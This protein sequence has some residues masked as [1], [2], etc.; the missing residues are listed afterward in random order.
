VL[1]VDLDG[2]SAVN[3][4]LGHAAGDQLLVQSA[5]RLRASVRESDI[6]ARLSGDEF[7][8]ALTE[9]RTGADAAVAARNVITALS[10]SSALGSGSAFISASVGIALFPADGES[11][12]TLLQH[13]DMAMYRAKQQ[14]RGQF[15]FFEASM[16]A[17]VQRRIELEGELRLALERGEFELHYQPQLDLRCARLIGGEALIRWRHPSKGMVPPLQFIGHAETN[18]LIEPIGRWALEMACAQFVSWR[19]Q[20]VPIE[21]VSVNVSPRQFRNPDFVRTVSE[22]LTRAGM[23]NAFMFGPLLGAIAL[24]SNE[25]QFSSVPTWTTNL[26]QLL[27]GCALGARFEK[28]LPGT[29]GRYAGAVL[30]SVLIAIALAAALSVALARLTGLP[31][32]SLVLAIAPGG[33]AEMCI[34]AKVLQLGVPLVT[35]AHVTRVLVLI[36]ATA[37]LYRFARYLRSRAAR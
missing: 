22:A 27:L 3:D 6:V 34:T 15:A 32:A 33:I 31:A 12:E 36:N 9:V 35:A 21:H 7:A 24:T 30:A 26:G 10:G 29:L 28:H 18:G 19:E 4:S 5:A 20:G 2:F 1:F 23:P 17:E 8:V 16:N 14:G 37:P 11:A 13:A 25:V